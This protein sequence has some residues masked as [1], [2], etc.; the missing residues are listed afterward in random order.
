MA[1]AGAAGAGLAAVAAAGPFP[2]A[3]WAV[4]PTGAV[5]SVHCAPSHQRSGPP[6]STGFSYQPGDGISK[7]DSYADVTR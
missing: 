7:A 3:G 6:T 1:G 5:C 4:P 2:M